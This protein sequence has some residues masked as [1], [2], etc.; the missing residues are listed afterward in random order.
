MT[1]AFTYGSTSGVTK[2][3]AMKAAVA[4]IFE[5]LRVFDIVAVVTVSNATQEPQTLRT[6]YGE[7]VSY[8]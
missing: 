2:L 3:D 7:F 4:A 6:D 5:T 8:R 1:S